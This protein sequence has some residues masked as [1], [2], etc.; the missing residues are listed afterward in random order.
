[1]KN[2]NKRLKFSKNKLSKRMAITEVIIDAG[3]SQVSN[4]EIFRKNQDSVAEKC[5][6]KSSFIF[7]TVIGD[8]VIPTSDISATVRK[9]LKHVTKW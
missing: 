1:M 4:V 6:V 2:I 5:P 9:N 8:V 7:K 3:H